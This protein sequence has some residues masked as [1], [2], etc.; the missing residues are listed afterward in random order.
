M[1]VV[2]TNTLAYLHLPTAQTDDVVAL[3]HKDLAWP[4][5]LP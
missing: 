2:D 1:I 5:P 3:L 4:A